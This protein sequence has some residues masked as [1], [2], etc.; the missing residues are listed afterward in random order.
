MAS[1]RNIERA[2]VREV[3]TAGDTY[4]ILLVMLFLDY[5]AISLLPANRWSRL[6]VV[7]AV[8]LTLLVALHTSHARGRLVRLAA[9]VFM[10]GVLLA[11]LET[12]LD[13]PVFTGST[14]AIIF[15]M[16]VTTPFVILRRILD[17]PT[18]NMETVIGAIDVY[19]LIGITFYA[20]YSSIAA[21]SD[22]AFFNQLANPSQNQLLYFSF[23]T[24][25]T[26]GY[27][28]LSPATDLGRALVV[29]EAVIGQIFLVTLVARLVALYGLRRPEPVGRGRRRPGHDD[30]DGPADGL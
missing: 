20:V 12:A 27:G 28:D 4:L 29:F 23:V 13:R 15:V 24:L 21:H 18:V 11:G 2:T 17:H 19:L 26:L 6:G 10:V 8:G 9:V 25:T 1:F 3:L 16:L 14:N 7:I 5:F 30:D 22:H